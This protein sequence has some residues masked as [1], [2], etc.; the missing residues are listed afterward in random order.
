M[1]KSLEPVDVL[2]HEGLVEVRV[3][4]PDLLDLRLAHRPAR[5]VAGGVA[6]AD[7]G[8]DH[9]H[10]GDDDEDDDELEEALEDVA[11]GRSPRWGPPT[12]GPTS[13]RLTRRGTP[14]SA[15]P[16]PGSRR[17]RG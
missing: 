15:T 10:E 16:G 14:R 12:A 5:E 1:T 8:E 11:H 13:T 7:A 4:L 2:L 3:V 17:R 9:H 6:A